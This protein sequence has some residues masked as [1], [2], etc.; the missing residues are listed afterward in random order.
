MNQNLIGNKKTRQGLDSF[1][2]IKLSDAG[3]SLNNFVN[4]T[5]PVDTSTA[6]VWKSYIRKL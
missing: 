6:E 2:L 3:N 5:P 1:L 4:I